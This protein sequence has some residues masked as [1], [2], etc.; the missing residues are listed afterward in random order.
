[1]A[2]MQEVVGAWQS[3]LN[4][5]ENWEALVKGVEPKVGGCGLVYE[6]PNPIE[7]PNESFAIAD[8]RELD[9]SEPHKHINGETEIYFVIQGAGKIAVGSEMRDLIKGDV[10]VTP[11]DTVHVTLPDDELILAVVNT[12]PFNADNY[13]VLDENDQAIAK[14]LVHLRAD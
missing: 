2:D 14:I 4:T 11:P 12:P 7:R 5:V 6:L 9:I 8:M 3:Y 10:V 1:M 13:V